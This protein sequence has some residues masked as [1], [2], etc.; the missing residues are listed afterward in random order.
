MVDH[1]LR[2][3]DEGEGETLS[4]Q[5]LSGLNW[6]VLASAVRFVAQFGI[7]IALARL[8]PPEDFGI[9]GIAYIVTGFASTLANLGFGPALIQ[10]TELTERHVRVAHTLTVLVSAVMMVVLFASAERVAGFFGDGR[11]A[12]VLQV[13]SLT[14]PV[15]GF[16]T[17]AGALLTRRLAFDVLV[18]IE[19]FASVIGYGGVAVVMAVAGYG[20]WS[21]VGGTLVQTVLATSLTYAAVRH[22]ARPL[23]GR[24]EI[25]DLF[26]F[27]AGMSLT[28]LAN[29]FARQGDYFVV[30]RLM[31]ATSLGFYSRAYSLM[32]LP[33]SFFGDSLSRVLFPAA[34]KVQGDAER[35]QRAFFTAF[36]LSVAVSLPISLGVAVLAPE[37]VLVLYGDRWAATIPLLQ[38]LALFGVFRMSYNTAAAFVRARGQAYRLLLSQVIYGVLVVGGSWW[39]GTRWGLEGV[40]WSVGGA[41]FAMWLLVAGFATRA[42]SVPLVPF[43]RLTLRA[44][45]PG[46]GVALVLLGLASG[47]RALGLPRPVLLGIAAVVLGSLTLLGLFQQA[48]RFDNPAI[49]AMLNRAFARIAAARHGIGRGFYR[50]TR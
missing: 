26:R 18:R 1:H 45:V 27:S 7:G 6:Q 33:L 39:A 8:L 20:Y 19:L 9:V 34:S 37:I 4:S 49:N 31:D 48:R 41:M 42:A 2:M 11:V 43:V 50:D 36:S 10:R 12:P 28:S 32:Q 5:T 14:F 16:G 24:A 40:A 15:T 22:D 21:L 47:S 29:Y 13:L 17:A 46:L 25:R 38:I 30:G 3:A 44:A 35:F 23:T